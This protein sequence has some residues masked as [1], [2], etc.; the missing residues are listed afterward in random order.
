[1]NIP[2]EKSYPTSAGQCNDCGGFGCKTCD[3][4]GWLPVGHPNI[5]KCLR[6]VCAEP[7]APNHV[8]VYCS[9]ACALIDGG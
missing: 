2:K 1:M 8:A 3:D 4:K 7:L 6:E 9:N 5:R